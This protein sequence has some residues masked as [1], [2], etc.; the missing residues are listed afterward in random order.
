MYHVYHNQAVALICSFISS[1]FFLSYSQSLKKLSHFPQALC[2]VQV[3]TWYTCGTVGVSIVY[4]G[5]RQLL[6]I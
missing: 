3:E 4:S 6:H 1:F 5:I 2:D